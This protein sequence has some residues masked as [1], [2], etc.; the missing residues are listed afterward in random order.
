[1]T[2]ICGTLQN[3]WVMGNSG[4]YDI[5]FVLFILSINKKDMSYPA[6][7]NHY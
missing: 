3:R 7:D 2:N 5:Y 4:I 6:V 1:M